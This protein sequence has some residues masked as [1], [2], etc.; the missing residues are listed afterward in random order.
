M[1]Q[2]VDGLLSGAVA[3][4]VFPGTSICVRTSRRVLHSFSD[5]H[6]EV[7]PG[8]RVAND[9]TVWDLASLTKALA[10]TPIAMTMVHQNILDLD[11]PVRD[12]LPDV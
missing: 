2:A 10:T 8:V 1:F 7:R 9:Q 6:A 12:V 5:G 3:H 4:G 11:R